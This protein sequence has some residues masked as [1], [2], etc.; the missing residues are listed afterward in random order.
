MR[1]L[2]YYVTN[3]FGGGGTNVSRFFSYIDLLEGSGVRLLINYYFLENDFVDKTGF[4]TKELSKLKTYSEFYDFVSDIQ[5][6]FISDGKVS[7]SYVKSK[8]SYQPEILIDS[9]SGNILRDSSEYIL[10]NFT[11]IKDHYL[12]IIEK[13]HSFCEKHNIDYAIAMDLALKYTYKGN[14]SDNESYSAIREKIEEYIDA[15]K[16][17]L[18]LTLGDYVKND[19]HHSIIVPIHGANL[20][21]YINYLLAVVDLEEKHRK[22]F[23]GFAI[24]G[25]GQI[26]RIDVKNFM[27]AKSENTLDK[28]GAVCALIKR[29]RAI[30]D[31]KGDRRSL[32]ILGSAGIKNLIAFIYAGATSFDCHTP[33]RR[34]SDGNLISKKSLKQNTPIDGAE[35]SKFLIPLLN[36][37]LEVLPNDTVYKYADLNTI[38]SNMGCDCLVCRK[39]PIGKIKELYCGDTEDN[40]FA[41]IL[42]FIHA[43]WQYSFLLKKM[44]I[45]IELDNSRK[46]VQDFVEQIADKKFKDVN[47]YLINYID[48]LDS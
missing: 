6:K 5:K 32:H 8:I 20:D 19:F 36:S 24:G 11:K 39:Y 41:K 30:I 12:D 14:E 13:Y 28:I 45:I 38:N 16:D 47:M 26:S 42:I 25:I 40:Y 17:L 9:G 35:W 23:D 1:K 44:E 2:F 10:K 7:K 46:A 3:D 31:A 21:S 33:W 15:N 22:R 48:N 37:R 43:A 34:S 29:S 18:D 27:G 4:N